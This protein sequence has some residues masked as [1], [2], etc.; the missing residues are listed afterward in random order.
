MN[1][2]LPTKTTLGKRPRQTSASS[3]TNVDNDNAEYN[4]EDEKNEMSQKYE[5]HLP[6][7]I[8]VNLANGTDSFL[9]DPPLTLHCELPP[10]KPLTFSSSEDYEVHYSQ[11]HT[12]RCQEC[13]RNFPSDHYLRLH[14]TE[15]HDSF[16]AVKR[17]RGEPTVRQ[18]KMVLLD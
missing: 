3:V 1:I 16:A 11:Q 17:Q 18:H 8:H 9:A 2:M 15:N 4:S 14:I 5:A 10:H 7:F 6:K 12:N 13:Q